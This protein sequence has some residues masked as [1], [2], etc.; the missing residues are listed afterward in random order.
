MAGSWEHLASF[1]ARAVAG[2]L[3]A[4]FLYMALFMY[5]DE[6]GKQQNRLVNLWIAVA[7]REA[8][9]LSAHAALIRRSSQ[10]ALAGFQ[11]LFGDRLL[12]LRT[13]AISL[14]LSLCSNTLVSATDKEFT[15]PAI[16]ITL[17]SLVFG[18]YG[19]YGAPELFRR[20]RPR[21]ALV[22]LGCLLLLY[23]LV[24]VRMDMADSKET[25]GTDAVDFVAILI[26]SCSFGLVCDLLL[27]TVNRTLLR[28]MAK[29]TSAALL[30]AGMA[31]NLLLAVVLADSLRYIY[32][33]YR[34]PARS[35]DPLFVL[36]DRMTSTDSLGGDIILG[37]I[38]AWAFSTNFFTML[39]AASVVLVLVAAL[40][41]RF[42]W[43]LLGRTVSAIY[44]WE[45]LSSRK[46]QF[47]AAAA[48]L[49]F[50]V[51]RFSSLFR[52]FK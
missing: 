12:T 39:T 45:I 23:Q 46:V 9:A 41:H 18:V 40:V 2:L 47:S 19:V 38:T 13:L 50:A 17:F 30:F 22:L 51:P 5:Q 1:L 37:I 35:G 11:D 26:I 7:E 52:L 33:G 14:A 25:L 44:A 8:S 4:A 6:R 31:Y 15:F 48:C 21:A 28:L 20:K 16:P 10:L 27:L 49:L 24:L 3:G 29:T 42:T 32:S 36:F 43:P 34:G